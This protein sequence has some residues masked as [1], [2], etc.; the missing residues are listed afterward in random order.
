MRV[1]KKQI[2][3]GIS[4]YLKEEVIAKIT[5]KPV[6]MA[7]AFAVK[8][9]Q[10]DNGIVDSV[11]N[12]SIVGYALQADSEG[13]YDLTNAVKAITEVMDGYGTFDFELPIVKTKMSFNKSDIEK[14]KQFIEGA[15]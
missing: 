3:D 14:M 4:R 12:N 10:A 2:I 8:M 6:K 5:D 15:M 13:T 1:S 7:L 9:I 11:M